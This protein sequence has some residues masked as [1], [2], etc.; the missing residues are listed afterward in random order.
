[1]VFK[2]INYV[3]SLL[4]RLIDVVRQYFKENGVAIVILLA[5]VYCFRSRYP[6]GSFTQGFLL[7]SSSSSSSS[8]ESSTANSK[9]NREEEMRQAR[10]RQQEI[11]N[12]RA[13]E[14][15][16]KQKEKEVKEK[17]RK[18][19]I[20]K[21]KESGDSGYRLG[22]NPMNRSNTNSY[23]PKHRKPPGT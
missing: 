4:N 2:A 6:K 10:Q 11:A 22:G 23:R 7:S 14:S 18:N 16:I 3:A 20:A 12:E 13:K 9:I 8:S 1:M 17:D 5:I 19:H 21:K 15:A